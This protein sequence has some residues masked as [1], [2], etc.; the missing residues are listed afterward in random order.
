MT[1]TKEDILLANGFRPYRK[2]ALAWAKQ[3]TKDGTINTLEGVMSYKAGDYIC[4]GEDNESW[5]IKKDIFEKTYVESPWS[6]G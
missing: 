3:S 6:N 1:Q 5:A 2:T 4:I